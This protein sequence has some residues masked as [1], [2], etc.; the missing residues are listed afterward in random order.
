M[1]KSPQFPIYLGLTILAILA[2]VIYG[3]TRGLFD[4]LVQAGNERSLS[5]RKA[6][7]LGVGLSL[8]LFAASLLAW[9]GWFL[10]GPHGTPTIQLALILPM[11][12]AFAWLK[13][14]KTA[15]NALEQIH[16]HN[17]VGFQVD[18]IVGVIFLALLAMGLLPAIFAI[19]AG[20][21]DIAV[22]ISAT[23]IARRMAAEP[24]RH[25]RSALIWNLAGLVDFVVAIGIG[26]LSAPSRFQL[27]SLD[28]PNVM[29]L[30]FP[31]VLIPAFLVPISIILHVLSLRDLRRQAR[32]VERPTPRAISIA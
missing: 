9:H 19:P 32:Q 20:L 15:A 17:W 21:G 8:W 7:S 31:L 1:G 24:G 30:R 4:A 2:I 6:T 12:V 16:S 18:R 11:A 5:R 10:V 26:F 28:H 13:L 25:G 23:L 3:L 29:I 27:L 22:G 14:D